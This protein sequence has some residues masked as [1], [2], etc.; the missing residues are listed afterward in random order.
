M[1]SGRPPEE[2]GK[3]W[4]LHSGDI[5]AE[6]MIGGVLPSNFGWR[7][8]DETAGGPE[9]AAAEGP[10]PAVVARFFRHDLMRMV[11]YWPILVSSMHGK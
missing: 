1:E 7:Q 6:T 3:F 9:L 4:M 5:S 10:K 11:G 8:A 2:T